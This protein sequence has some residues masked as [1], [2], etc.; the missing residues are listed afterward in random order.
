MQ[1]NLATDLAGGR[2]SR[3][4]KRVPIGGS[5]LRG[6]G[7]AGRRLSRRR[8]MA[9]V[10]LDRG[11]VRSMVLANLEEVEN[12]TRLSICRLYSVTLYQPLGWL[13]M[14]LVSGSAVGC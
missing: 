14:Y 9:Y 6:D 10:D 4:S 3:L 11:L 13:P 7:D 1:F 2:G 12:Q 5:E 8:D